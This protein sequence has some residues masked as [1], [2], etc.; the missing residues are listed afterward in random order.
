M[1]RLRSTRSLQWRLRNEMAEFTCSDC[2]LW[3]GRCTRDRQ[4]RWSLSLSRLA[5]S[6]AC[7]NICLPEKKVLEAN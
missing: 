1:F 3:C 6:S 4:D 7:A 5:L 2:V